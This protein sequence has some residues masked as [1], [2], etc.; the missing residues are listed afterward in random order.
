[1]SLP[2]A[3]KRKMYGCAIPPPGIRP[4]PRWTLSQE[5]P[6]A[7]GNLGEGLFPDAYAPS[8]RHGK[9]RIMSDGPS[10][11]FPLRKRR[12]NTVSGREE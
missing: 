11:S 2:M 12:R 9:R 5:Y 8:K 1:M 7:L 6:P 4:R 3:K 10:G